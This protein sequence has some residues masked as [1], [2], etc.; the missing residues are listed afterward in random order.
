MVSILNMDKSSDFSIFEIGTNKFFEIRELTKL[1]QPSQIFITN[2]LSTHLENFKNKKNIAKEKSDIFNKSFNPSA[3][4]LY[5]Q[6]KSRSEYVINNIAK[7]QKL[8]KIIKIGKKTDDSFIN[9][10]QKL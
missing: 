1:V 5:F 10:I 8:K 9:K 3:S 4:I 2:I 6:N 7:T